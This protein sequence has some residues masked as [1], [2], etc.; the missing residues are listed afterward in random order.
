MELNLLSAHLH[1]VVSSKI[2]YE[3]PREYEYLNTSSP[4]PWLLYHSHI[5]KKKKNDPS[6]KAPLLMSEVP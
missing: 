6:L 5:V 3:I 1:E 2:L 4:F